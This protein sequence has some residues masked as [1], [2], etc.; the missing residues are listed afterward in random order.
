MYQYLVVLFTWIGCTLK[1]TISARGLD[2]I[3]TEIKYIKPFNRTHPEYFILFQRTPPGF[4]K[5]EYLSCDIDC[6]YV[7]TA[8]FTVHVVSFTN[9][10][11]VINTLKITHQKKISQIY[12]SLEVKFEVLKQS[13]KKKYKINLHSMSNLLWIFLVA[14]LLSL[15]PPVSNSD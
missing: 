15:L 6:I 3:V 1:P 12:N 7:F 10:L 8:S 5:I 11:R 9:V 14:S 4:L 13:D 2:R